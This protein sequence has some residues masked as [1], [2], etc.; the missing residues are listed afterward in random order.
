MIFTVKVLSRGIPTILP[1]SPPSEPF[2]R[3]HTRQI[4]GGLFILAGAFKL[5]VPFLGGPNF[6][7]FARALHLPFPQLFALALPLIEIGG[8]ACLLLN[9]HIRPAAA[10]LAI[11]MIFAIGLVGAPGLRGQAIKIGAT[12]IGTEAW[13]VPLEVMLLIAMLFLTFERKK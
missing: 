2:A 11:D 12:S 3:R 9:R 6:A 1:T 4:S 10:I 7:D 13:R 8:G 5:I